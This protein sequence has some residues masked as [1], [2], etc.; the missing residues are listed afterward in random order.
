MKRGSFRRMVLVFVILVSLLNIISNLM[1]YD[2]YFN[3]SRS[4][5]LHASNQGSIGFSVEGDTV[6][7]LISIVSPTN[8]S[9][10]SHRTGIDYT[11]SDS[12]LRTCWYSL[13]GGVTNVSLTC[14]NN[15]TGITSSTGSNAWRV[16]ANDSRNNVNFSA[17]TFVVSIPS[18]APATAETGGG[19]SGGSTALPVI[20]SSFSVSPEEM[21]LFLV[22]GEHSEKKIKVTNTGGRALTINIGVGTIGNIV[23]SNIN[24]LVLGP[25]EEKSIILSIVAPDYGIN[26]GRIIFSSGSLKKE[27]FVIVNVK[28]EKSLFDVSITLPEQYNVVSPGENIKSFVSMVPVGP[29]IEADVTVNYII[30]D[31]EGNVLLKE[32]ETFFISEAKNFI[33]DFKIPKELGPGDYLV[34]IEV[35]YPEGF[36]TSSVHFSIKETRINFWIIST[37][38]F[39]IIAIIVVIFS[40]LRYKK[41]KKY[42]LKKE[43]KK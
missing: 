43:K 21:N 38:V 13:D 36:A 33:K 27:V 1:L 28:S 23:S 39:F 15:V 14:G 30:K 5:T 16:Y 8:T 10:T 17:V 31:F 32:S 7:P 29:S 6:H 42:V 34:G 12:N 24:Q 26:A 19:A 40:I 2:N 35:I 41:S 25:G 18:V 11:V 3:F 20:A 9:Y 22:S 37:I 4:V